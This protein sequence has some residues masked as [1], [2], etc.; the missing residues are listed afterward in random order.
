[1]EVRCQWKLGGGGGW[2]LSGSGSQVPA[3]TGGWDTVFTESK[4]KVQSAISQWS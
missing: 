2:E 1:M 4:V 3:G